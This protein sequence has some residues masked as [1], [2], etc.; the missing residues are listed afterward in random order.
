MPAT[1]KD[2]VRLAVIGFL[3]ATTVG[4]LIGV[5]G[6][7]D[8]WPAAL[9]TAVPVGVGVSIAFFLYYRSKGH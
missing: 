2:P 8:P 1:S 4:L 9:A 7:G 6:Y 5:V 3:A